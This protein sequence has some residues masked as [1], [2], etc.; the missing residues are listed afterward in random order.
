[1]YFRLKLCVPVLLAIASL[2]LTPHITPQAQAQTPLCL[3][4]VV[5]GIDNMIIYM[6]KGPVGGFNMVGLYT[7]PGGATSAPAIVESAQGRIDIFVRG[8][9]NALWHRWRENGVWNWWVS[10][11]GV[12]TSGPD[13]IGTTSMVGTLEIK[14]VVR[15]AD[16][17]LYMLTYRPTSSRWESLGQAPGGAAGD[18]SIA[19]WGIDFFELVT[20]SMS[21]DKVYSN[22]FMRGA[23]R[24]WQDMGM[25]IYDS[26]ATS[27]TYQATTYVRGK[28]NQLYR[29]GRYELGM[30]PIERL[31]PPPGGYI[32][33]GPGT[34]SGAY[35]QNGSDVVVVRAPD[36]TLYWRE[37]S[38]YSAPFTNWETVG[39][40]GNTDPDITRIRCN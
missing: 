5:R 29:R 37:Y 1:M 25:N 21:A 13:A 10:R 38:P 27:G 40:R 7:P 20:R 14:V 3:G 28:D 17:G 23:W 12:L 39:V 31:E 33:S 26:P 34:D 15:G 4:V 22:S 9:D 35:Q 19:R 36:G 32:V 16:N 18:P 11:G 24:G 30:D 8:A 2:L 6:E